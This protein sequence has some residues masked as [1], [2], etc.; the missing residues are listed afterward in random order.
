MNVPDVY[1]IRLKFKQKDGSLRV[2]YDTIIVDQHTT[3][4]FLGR[5]CYFL[6]H[7]CPDEYFRDQS[8]S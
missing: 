6:L 7:A 4:P 8:S 2:E 1:T 3:I 5:A